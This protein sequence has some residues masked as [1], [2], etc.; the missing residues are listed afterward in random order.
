MEPD[1]PVDTDYQPKP[2]DMNRLDFLR[3]GATAAAG[4]LVTTVGLS[5]LMASFTGCVS[6]QSQC[7]NIG[8]QLYSLRDAMSDSVPSTLEKVAK[9]GYKTLETAGYSDGKLYGYEPAE[10][11]RMV[12]SLGM[13]VTSAH[14]G[15]DY[16]AENEAEVMQWWDTALDAQAAVGCKYAIQ[17]SFPIGATLEEI[18]VYCDYFNKVGEM[19]K[20]KGI[21]FGF[22][23]H[24]GEFAKIGDTT[25]YDYMIAN[26]D[27][28]KV[29]FELDVYWA[30][31][32]GVDP[33]AYINKYPDRIVLLHIKDESTI[34]ESE[35]IDFAPIFEALYQNNHCDFYV[36]VERYTLPPE[37]CVSRS[38]DFLNTSECVKV[39]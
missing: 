3:K 28:D 9:M 24:A 10:F 13:T 19:A 22:H 20:Q 14:L 17:P 30:I 1:A 38:F 12:E 29:C 36:E 39:Q 16:S 15:R 35:Q 18:K 32:G 27:P 23:N 7:K 25:I 21:K 4:A 33:V 37:N 2:I 34:G 8:L 5:A 6:T 31:K 26:T 11:R